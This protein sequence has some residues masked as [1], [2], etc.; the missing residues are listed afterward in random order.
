M[1]WIDSNLG[2]NFSPE[3]MQAIANARNID[4]TIRKHAIEKLKK[5][6]PREMT[7]Q[8]LKDEAQRLGIRGY[9]RLNKVDLQL[10]IQNVKIKKEEINKVVRA[11]A[12]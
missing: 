4:P 11:T 1:H 9:S 7:I 6:N 5:L 8:E 12:G 3:E 10:E 2:E